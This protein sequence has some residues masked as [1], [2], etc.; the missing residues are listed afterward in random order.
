MALNPTWRDS[1]EG[2]EEKRLMER[3][4]KNGALPWCTQ[5]PSAQMIYVF[6]DGSVERHV[7]V[8]PGPCISKELWGASV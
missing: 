2:G 5:H 3:E 6:Q 4:V 1:L 7:C 8:S